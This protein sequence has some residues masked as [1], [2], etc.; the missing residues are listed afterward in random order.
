M[1]KARLVW[2]PEASQGCRKE[3]HRFS[4]SGTLCSP[5]PNNLRDKHWPCKQVWGQFPASLHLSERGRS[6]HRLS[7][8]FK[9]KASVETCNVFSH[10]QGNPERKKNSWLTF[11]S[12]LR[13]HFLFSLRKEE[14]LFRISTFKDSLELASYLSTVREA[15]QVRRTGARQWNCPVRQR[16]GSSEG[17]SRR[18]GREEERGTGAQS[19]SRWPLHHKA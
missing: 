9:V 5:L 10:L 17:G 4:Y 2:T 3:T 19:G 7:S 13:F 6:S 12:L 1:I 15:P 18:L 14:G 8:A 16:R 11:T